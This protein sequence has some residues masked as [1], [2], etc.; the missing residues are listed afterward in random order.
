MQRRHG[1]STSE[2]QLNH[3]FRSLH[4]ACGLVLLENGESTQQIQGLT[5]RVVLGHEAGRFFVEFSGCCFIADEMPFQLRLGH[6]IDTRFL[7]L[8]P[9]RRQGDIRHYAGRL[10]RLA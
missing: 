4:A 2:C 7:D 3:K 1:G 10:D 6:G 5:E 9:H 8:D